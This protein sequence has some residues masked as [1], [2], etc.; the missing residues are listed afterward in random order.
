MKSKNNN[1]WLFAFAD[2]AF[3]LLIAFTQIPLGLTFEEMVIPEAN[4]NNTYNKL[5]KK[6]VNFELRIHK[7]TEEEPNP[8][9][10]VMYLDKGGK[11]FGDRFPKKELR[12]RL[13]LV[14]KDSPAKPLIVPDEHSYTKDL[15]WAM[16]LV[17]EIWAQGSKVTVRPVIKQSGNNG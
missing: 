1:I 13:I 15:V 17:K 7:V 16:S 8:F 11:S 14:A 6:A 3:L 9:Q 12:D 2:L 4:P 5:D 10:L